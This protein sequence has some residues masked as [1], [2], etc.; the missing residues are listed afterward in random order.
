MMMMAV[1]AIAVLAV[2]MTTGP[3][4]AQDEAKSRTGKNAEEYE[5]PIPCSEEAQ[6][7]PDTTEVIDSG[8]YALFD[9]FWDYEVGHLSNNFC[10]PAVEYIPG[11]PDA[12]PATE[13]RNIRS[14]A[15]IHISK[16][17]FSIPDSYKVTAIDSGNSNGNSGAVT[18][19]TI[20]LADYPFLSHD[21]AVL[22]GNSLWWVRLDDPRTPADETSPLRIA[23]STDLLE[24]ADWYRD[25]N[26]DGTPEDPVQFRFAAV[27]VLKDGSPQEAHVLDAHFFAFDQLDPDAPDEKARWSNV[28]TAEAS[29][30]DM[31]TGEYRPMQFAFTK[32][33][34]YLVQAQVQ[35][36]VRKVRPD[37]VDPDDWSPIS[38]DE[39]ITSPVQWYT[40]HVGRE[41][42]LSV[43]ITAD[44]ETPNDASTT[45]TDGTVSFTV[46]AANGGPE[47]VD[48]AVVQVRLPEGLEYQAGSASVSDVNYE[49]GVISWP[50]GSVGVTDRNTLTFTADVGDQATRRLAA[51][52]E[53]RNLDVA[54]LDRDSADNF[55]SATVRLSSPRARPPRFGGVTRSIPE[56]ASAGAHAGDPVAASNPDARKL[57]YSLSGRCHD[58]FE[59]QSNGQ[60][61][62]ASGVRLDYQEQWDFPLTI[63]VSDRVD[64]SGAADPA[65]DD[66]VPALIQVIDTEDSAVHPTVTFSLSNSNP[67]LQPNLD[68]AHPVVGYTVKVDTQLHNLPEGASATYDWHEGDGYI[69]NWSDRIHSS[70]YPAQALSA[71]PATYTVHVKWDGGGVTATHTIEW[72]HPD[73][74][75][76]GPGN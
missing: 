17:V 56:H 44:D 41:A 64:A 10:P 20:D 39:S 1:L 31:F 34:V 23:F 3:T 70:Y 25:E 15:K 73:Q 52:A 58:W 42:G 69:H 35:G 36:H 59:V 62:L 9:A 65:D 40:F 50:L 14:D 13:P 71:G 7:G 16:T 11:N 21:D 26:E 53:I 74:Q 75:H 55:S 45:A 76:P 49:C 63:H 66:S 29:E 18:G 22:A 5:Y 6:P 43:E 30:I 54:D 33:G 24:E 68:L 19:P 8:Y 4:M 32:P 60:I 51:T 57:Y 48:E 27:H 28:E 12:R 37:G 38:P 47:D 67:S 61:T 2:A 72:F 46:N